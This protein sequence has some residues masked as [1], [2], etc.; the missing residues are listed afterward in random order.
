MHHPY[1]AQLLQ[2]TNLQCFN[3]RATKILDVQLERIRYSLHL[4]NC[5]NLKK[6][7]E[8]YHHGILSLRF[9]QSYFSK[10]HLQ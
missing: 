3:S 8:Q 7:Y 6:E 1:N 9:C 2:H 10:F 4:P 5:T